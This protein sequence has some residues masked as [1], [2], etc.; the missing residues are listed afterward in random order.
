MRNLRGEDF[1][2]SVILKQEVERSCGDGGVGWAGQG[3]AGLGRA[4]LAAGRGG[5][6]Y[7][8]FFL[9]YISSVLHIA[10]VFISRHLGPV[11]PTS[12]YTYHLVG[13]LTCPVIDNLGFTSISKDEAIEVK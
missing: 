6:I 8:K 10:A 5:V 1:Q 3:W 2:F 7:H 13:Y 12:V 11:I 4:G 9:L